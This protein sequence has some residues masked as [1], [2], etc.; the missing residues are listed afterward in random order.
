MSRFRSNC[1]VT[2]VV[3]RA[4]DDVISVTQCDRIASSMR[5]RLTTPLSRGL[6]GQTGA[7]GDGRELHFREWRYREQPVRRRAGQGDRDHQQCGG[8]GP[9][10]EGLRNIHRL[11]CKERRNSVGR[12]IA[13]L[14]M[15]RQSRCQPIEPDVNHRRCVKCQ[16]LADQQATDN[17]NSQGAPAVREPLPEPRPTAPRPAAPPWWSS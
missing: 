16:K 5:P 14:A 11:P 10:D 13:G 12:D 1:R 8:G 7:Y 17:R 9:P 6:L 15:F 4:L 3:P 2:L